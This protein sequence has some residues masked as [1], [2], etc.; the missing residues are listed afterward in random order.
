M[1]LDDSMVLFGAFRRIVTD[2]VVRSR[3]LHSTV[4][5]RW[6][7]KIAGSRGT[8]H[9]SLCS[10]SSH[11]AGTEEPCNGSIQPPMSPYEYLQYSEFH[12]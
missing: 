10:V 6:S 12:N 3:G 1:Q 5:C 11:A 9:S 2:I 7:G 8:R 4:L